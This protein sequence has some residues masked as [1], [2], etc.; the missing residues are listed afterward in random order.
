MNKEKQ[1]TVSSKMGIRLSHKP[2]SNI[3]ASSLQNLQFVIFTSYMQFSWKLFYILFI[4]H[5][6]YSEDSKTHHLYCGSGITVRH[7]YY[8]GTWIVYEESVFYMYNL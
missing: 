1:Y 4:F 3:T 7:G 6:L 2:T 8:G 5:L